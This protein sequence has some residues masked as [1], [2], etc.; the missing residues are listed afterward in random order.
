MVGCSFFKPEQ[1]QTHLT[2]NKKQLSEK[3]RREYKHIFTEALKQKMLGNYKEAYTLL[4]ECIEINPKSS[5]SKYEAG[6]IAYILK[7]RDV[8]IKFSKEAINLN[9]KNK[10]YKIQLAKIYYREGLFDKAIKVYKQLSRENP[11]EMDFLYQLGEIYSNTEKYSE[12][13]DVYNKIQE[14]TGTLNE[15]VCLA[16]VHIY[17]LQNKK[18]KAYKELQNLIDTFP[19]EYRYAGRL[20]ELYTENEEYEKAEKIYTNLL[21]YDNTNGLILLSVSNFYTKINNKEKSFKYLKKAFVNKELDIN[22]KVLVLIQHIQ[23]ENENSS[24]EKTYSLIS[25]LIENHPN[26]AIVHDI[27]ANYLIKEKQ[28]KQARS[29]IR[30][31]LSLDKSKYDLW[32]QLMRLELELEDFNAMF[33]ES[34]EAIEYFPNQALCYFFNGY[35]AFQIGKYK[36]ASV[37]LNDGVDLVLDNNDLK[38]QFY[39]FIGETYSKLKDYEQADEAFDEG[40]LIEPNNKQILNNYSYYLANRGEKLKYAEEMIVRCLELEPDN[41]TYLDTYAWILYRAKKF[42]KA[43]ETMQKAI[44][45]GGKNR[46]VILEHYGDILY[47][48]GSAKQAVVQWNKAL[49]L[50]SNSEKLK[51]KAEQGSLLED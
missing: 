20:A 3:D 35:S 47:K 33:E 49:E 10:W 1:M 5:A 40:L 27:Y 13:I 46:P 39:T 24:G 21:K 29:Q 36:E 22:T 11:R 34:K 32:E 42:E 23:N 44:E 4:N 8:A 19:N 43:L 38:I 48:S 45:L 7:D 37:S 14:K 51:Q 25:L 12:A 15:N 26:E 30:Q 2:N 41:V 6:A 31:A 18:D 9:K 28:Y 17:M 16:K 50:G